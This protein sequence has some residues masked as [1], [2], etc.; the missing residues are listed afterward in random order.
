MAKPKTLWGK[1]KKGREDTTEFSNVK[2]SLGVSERERERIEES[3]HTHSISCWVKSAGV[4][5]NE[6]W[7]QQRVKTSERKGEKKLKPIEDKT[8]CVCNFLALLNTA[9]FS[10]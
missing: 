8:R 10:T 7:Q 3:T 1:N 2:D 9:F 5:S 4:K 6:P